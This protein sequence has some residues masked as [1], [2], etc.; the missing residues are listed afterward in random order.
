MRE[1]IVMALLLTSPSA[2]QSGTNGDYQAAYD[3][4]FRSSFR[5]RSI[6]QCRASAKNAATAKI[7]VTPI[8]ACVTD[9]LLATKSVD[10][11]KTQ[12]LATELQSIS[13]EC[14]A[15]NPPAISSRR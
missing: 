4:A 7:D 3:I 8:C 5:S 15:A 1:M 2:V 11:L 14:I 10:E 9:R 12:P 6:E 13:T